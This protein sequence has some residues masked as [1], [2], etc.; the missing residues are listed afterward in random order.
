MYNFYH[1]ISCYA[2]RDE[3]ISLLTQQRSAASH[4][5]TASVAAITQL[6]D[7]NR[8]L[9]TEKDQIL[10]VISEKTKENRKLKDESHKMMNV[11]A[12]ARAALSKVNS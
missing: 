8:A 7:A 2:E 5:T 1:S 11:V 3:V 10:S 4:N 9:I 6:E 12:E